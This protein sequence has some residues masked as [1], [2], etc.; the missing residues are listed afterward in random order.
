MSMVRTHAW[1][2]MGTTARLVVVGGDETLVALATDRIDTLEQ[3]W[4]RF[5]P[6]SEI[7][8]LNAA[9]GTPCVVS[10]DTAL[11][12]EQLVIAWQRTGGRFDPTVLD[13]LLALGYDRAWPFAHAGSSSEAVV[14]PGCHGIEV[15]RRSGLVWLPDG[16][17]LDPGG[18][19]KGLAADL[20]ASALMMAGADGVLVELGGDVR[21]VGDAP[22][23]G[24]WRVE[25]ED[26]VAPT[27]T[28]AVVQTTDGGVATSST[29]K[30]RWRLAADQ[31]H[32]EVHHVV[33]PRTGRSALTAATS[34]TALA[35]SAALAEVGATVALLDGDL[36]GA[37]WVFAALLADSDGSTRCLGDDTLFRR[38]DVAAAQA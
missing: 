38:L 9:A 11:L 27:E 19:G 22:D 16:V 21:V 17:H 10:D 2:A 30:R 29:S 37:P 25:I 20:V 36:A 12:V 24:A 1:A 34:A 6:T 3:R 13:T 4:S 8:R 33:D 7:S 35:P 14:S 28:I 15:D 23:G 5:L 32:R 18:L 26:P 31:H